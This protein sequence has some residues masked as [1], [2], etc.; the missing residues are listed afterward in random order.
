MLGD[1]DS[2]Q[3]K[4]DSGKMKKKLKQKD[5]KDDL[6]RQKV[7]HR[8]N[9][10]SSDALLEKRQDVS[11][12]NCDGDK[13]VC[14][15]DSLQDKTETASPAKR[16]KR[17]AKE[18]ETPLPVTKAE[19]YDAP[20]QTHRT[21]DSNDGS[22]GDSDTCDIEED[23]FPPGSSNSEWSDLDDDQNSDA[24]TNTAPSNSK[25]KQLE[26]FKSYMGITDADMEKLGSR[27]KAVAETVQERACQKQGRVPEVIVFH[28]PAKKKKVHTSSASTTCCWLSVWIRCIGEPWNEDHPWSRSKWS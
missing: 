1:K 11:N 25:L 21:S 12:R 2:I 18:M 10:L 28:D 8:K 6:F 7:K 19:E 16:K 15:P 5:I 20:V 13:Q 3:G 23:E 27:K 24:Q 4:D 26:K 17:K 9:R 14:E 22:D